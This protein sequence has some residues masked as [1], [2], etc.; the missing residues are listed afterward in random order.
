MQIIDHGMWVRYQPDVVPSY[1]PR[2]AIYLKRESDG[3]DW[4]DYI[5]PSDPNR[6][7]YVG[8]DPTIKSNF[9]EHTIKC[10][11]FWH[12][13]FKLHMI[14]AAVL[15]PTML[16][17]ISQQVIEIVGHSCDDPHAEFSRKV[18]D[19]ATESFSVFTPPPA[20]PSK[21]EQTILDR[22]DAIAARLGKLEG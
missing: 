6:A 13:D 4:Y 3:A 20:P 17:P 1:M 16:W 22:L 15:D 19:P 21:I 7:S 18:Y 14:G 5:R 9:Q 2:N 10:G 12:P 11:V 8:F